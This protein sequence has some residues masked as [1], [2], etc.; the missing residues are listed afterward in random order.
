MKATASVSILPRAGTWN[1]P[2]RCRSFM[3]FIYSVLLAL[4]LLV[5]LPKFLVDALRHGKYVTG[6]RERLG[7]LERLD[8]NGQPVLWLHC[9]SVG[10]TQAARP[11]VQAIRGKFPQYLIAVS[12]VTV[13]GQQLAR[14]IFKKEARRVFYFPLDWRWTVRRALKAINPSVVLIMET[15]LW[16]GFLRECRAQRI[17]VAVVNGRLSQ[18]S[19]QRYKLVRP[20]VSKVVNCLDLAVM[21]TEADAN[22]I[23][24]LGLESDRVFVSGSV[25]FDAG[26]MNESSALTSELR[27][28]F[29]FENRQVIL[30]ASTHDPEE[31]IILAAFR[32]LQSKGARLVIAPRHPE[33][34]ADVASLLNAS[35]LSWARRSDRPSQKDSECEV[36]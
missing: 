7:F 18:R 2:S 14:E 1:E 25:K 24:A 28:R 15:E 21:Q 29:N 32:Q 3:Y 13:T 19:F 22:R 11:L 27:Q 33:R 6:F 5:L 23:T 36:M 12:T 34:F 30:A 10:E 31:R 35:G 16:P 26:A 17:P 4:G 20:F 8:H 9:V